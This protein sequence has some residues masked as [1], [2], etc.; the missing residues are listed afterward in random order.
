MIYVRVS[1][2]EQVA[3][4][5]LETQ[6]RACRDHCRK[7]GLEVER[8]FRDEGESA[9]T[10]DRPALRAM[11][12]F[13][14]R[15]SKRLDVTAVVVYKFDRLARVVADH[16]MITTALKDLGIRLHSATEYTED[17]P[18]GEFTETIVSAASGPVRQQRQ[19][20]NVSPKM[21]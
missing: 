19:A 15:E 14:V 4:N 7:H 20:P 18:I 11:L 17:S 13:C 16:T 21:G 12:D 5:S 10:A 6:E 1:T 8:V 2:T 3:N 9:K